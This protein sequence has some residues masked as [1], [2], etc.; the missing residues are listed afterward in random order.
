MLVLSKPLANQTKATGKMAAAAAT[1]T[2]VQ[3]YM[4]PLIYYPDHIEDEYVS[5]QSD[6]VIIPQIV[7]NK[8]S[9]LYE[10][11]K[12]MLVDIVNHKTGIE[13]TACIGLPSQHSNTALYAPKWLLDNIGATLEED[14]IVSVEPHL[15]EVAQATLLIL[16]PMDTAIYH[17][18]VRDAFEAALDKFHVIQ[19]GA[20]IS[21]EIATL[22][23]YEVSAYVEKTEPE[24]LVRLG[25]EVKVEFIEPE[26][27]V[28]EF[29][30][31][32]RDLAKAREEEA[33]RVLAKAREEEAA[34]V[35]AQVKRTP[36]EI[37]LARLKYF[38]KK[39]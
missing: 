14:C 1:I 28:E 33:A 36:E 2:P 29:V 30:S 37:R 9:H 31:A 10:E 23:G 34:R 27:G 18:D 26:G 38:E 21:V 19:Q 11:G 6:T 8:W 24:V 16:R 17:S 22:G 35:S 32:A 3:L 15:E 5:E 12:P 25:G 20:L 4:Q 39:D 13:R 7:W